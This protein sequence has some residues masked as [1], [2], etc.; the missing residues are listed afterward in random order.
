MQIQSV[1]DLKT[2]VMQDLLLNSDVVAAVEGPL[3]LSAF[4]APEAAA[5]PRALSAISIGAAGS[6]GDYKLA[7]RVQG[8]P[9]VT[10]PVVDQIRNRAHD[11]VDVAHVGFILSIDPNIQ[12]LTAAPATVRPLQAG[13]SVFYHIGTA[14]TLGAFFKDNCSGQNVML[15]NNHVLA[16]ENLGAIGDPIVQPGPLDGGTATVGHLHRFKRLS[17]GKNLVDAACASLVEDFEKNTTV[18]GGPKIAGIRATPVDID[19]VVF[20]VGRT[21]GLTR[22]IVTAAELDN[23]AVRYSFATYTFD[24]QFEVQAQD[25]PFS[26]PGDSGSVILDE[27]GWIVGLLFAGSTKGG[28]FGHGRTYANPIGAVCRVLDITF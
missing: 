4:L 24:D 23:V 17:P 16:N 8:D 3:A 22:G 18:N 2:E 13:C 5:R 21:T 25:Q 27:D 26:Q 14:G 12:N 11:E 9:H 19:E 10:Q 20:K 1:R 15:S 6:G 7:V 28:N